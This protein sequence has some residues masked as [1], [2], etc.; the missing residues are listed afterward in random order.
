VGVPEAHAHRFR[1]QGEM[2]DA[3]SELFG[4]YPLSIVYGAAVMNTD[5]GCAM[6]TQTMSLF[7]VDSVYLEDLRVLED[8]CWRMKRP[9][10]GLATA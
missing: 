6:E 8:Y 5:I 10:S 4:P 9:I 7:G 3:Y 2:I 1:P